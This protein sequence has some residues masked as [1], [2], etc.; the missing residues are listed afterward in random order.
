ME[1]RHIGLSNVQVYRRILLELEVLLVSDKVSAFLGTN[2]RLNCDFDNRLCTHTQ[3]REKER[4][5]NDERGEEKEVK[6]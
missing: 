1:Y 6:K 3:R 2:K 5:R 4:K